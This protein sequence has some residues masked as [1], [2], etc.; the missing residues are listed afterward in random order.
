[1]LHGVGTIEP[2][3]KVQVAIIVVPAIADAI[4]DRGRS[5]PAKA[6]GH[7]AAKRFGVPDMD[8]Q[9]RLRHDLSPI[10]KAADHL[11][12][13]VR[14][15][16]TVHGDPAAVSRALRRN[17]LSEEAFPLVEEFETET[18]GAWPGLDADHHQARCR[19][20]LSV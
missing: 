12:L 4:R 13:S 20:R 11:D 8:L 17:Y 18:F 1:M 6:L 15:Q 10:D 7:L 19:L 16:L 3:A 9:R 2:G 14:E 5:A